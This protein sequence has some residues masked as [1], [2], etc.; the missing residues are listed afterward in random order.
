MLLSR[1][2]L[3]LQKHTIMNFGFGTIAIL[4]FFVCL[5]VYIKMIVI[6]WY[7]SKYCLNFILFEQ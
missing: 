5:F 4:F 3:I 6:L 1:F 2:T 7:S